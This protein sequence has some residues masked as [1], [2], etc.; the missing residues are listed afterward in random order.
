MLKRTSEIDRLVSD[1]L[2]LVGKG[3]AAVLGVV[4]EILVL[5]SK[6]LAGRTTSV[7]KAHG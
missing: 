2:F 1:G 6:T 5:M 3:A 7:S 4:T